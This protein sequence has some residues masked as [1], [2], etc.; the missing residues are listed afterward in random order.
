MVERKSWPLHVVPRRHKHTYTSMQ[1]QTCKNLINNLKK[2]NEQFLHVKLEKLTTQNSVLTNL[3]HTSMARWYQPTESCVWEYLL[4]GSNGMDKLRR[5]STLTSGFISYWNRSSHALESA[6]GEFFY[7][8]AQDGLLQH[9][10]T[11][12]QFLVEGVVMFI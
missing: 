1:M 3:N 11:M 12:T 5:G 7:W 2:I 6:F 9:I 4:W 10:L 8:S